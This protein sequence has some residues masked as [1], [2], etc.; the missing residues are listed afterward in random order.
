[1]GDSSR[2]SQNGEKDSGESGPKQGEVL[3]LVNAGLVGSSTPLRFLLGR[4][5]G[6]VWQCPWFQGKRSDCSTASVR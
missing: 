2:R 3:R 5:R 1:M 4:G 6:G